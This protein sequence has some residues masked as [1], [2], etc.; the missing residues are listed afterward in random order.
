MKLEDL[1]KEVWAVSDTHGCFEEFK[2]G[3]DKINFHENENIIV[4]HNGD[5]IDR[6][7]QS[8][9]NIMYIKNHPRI[10]A[11]PGNHDLMM[12]QYFRDQEIERGVWFGNGGVE[13]VKELLSLGMINIVNEGQQHQ[14]QGGDGTLFAATKEFIELIQW[15]EELPRYIEFDDWFVS[16]SGGNFN[17]GKTIEDQTDFTW[18]WSR[19]E[20]LKGEKLEG[21]QHVIGHTM[22]TVIRSEHFHV[23]EETFEA[24]FAPVAVP[25]AIA[26][27]GGVNIGGYLFFMKLDFNETKVVTIP[28]KNTEKTE[29]IKEKLELPASQIRQLKEEGKL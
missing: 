24:E 29:A 19:D 26:I 4:I 13:V 14:F 21:K 6:G 5:A 25:G 9:P 12:V 22:T 15:I 11:T 3:L 28:S 18:T 27:D 1:T 7:P 17:N 23:Y 2:E 8:I 10:L 16:H 20:F